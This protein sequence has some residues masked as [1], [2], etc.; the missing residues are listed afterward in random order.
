M[1]RNRCELL[2]TELDE[3]GAG[4]GSTGDLRVHV[5]ELLPG[6]RGLVQL[7]HR[8]PH[9][10]EAWGTLLRLVGAPSRDRVPTA[11]PAFGACGG[12]AWQHLSYPA[13]LEQKRQRVVHAFAAHAATAQLLVPAVRPSPAVLGYRNKGKYVVGTDGERVILGA[14]APRT[15]SIVATTGCQVVAP[16]IDEVAEWT[17][18]AADAAALVPYSEATH[19][20]E[21]RYVVIRANRLHDVLVALVVTQQCPV[22]KLERVAAALRNHPAIRTIVAVRNDRRDGAILPLGAPTEVLFGDGTLSETLADAVIQL[23]AVE[24]LQVNL[25]QADAMYSYVADCI[26]PAAG[27]RVVDL[28][29]GL[30]GISLHLAARGADVT[31]IE[32]ESA[33]IAALRQAATAAGRDID[34]RVG[35]A[36]TVQRVTPLPD[37]IVVNPPRKG[38]DAATRAALIALAPATLVYVS[39]GPQSLAADLVELLNAGYVVV[40][41]QPFDLMP[42][43]AQIETVVCLQRSETTNGATL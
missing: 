9:R 38:L 8:S 17:R 14:F 2:A 40:S 26:E 42:H 24:F 37:A 31:A 13:Q 34:A 30:G 19:Q 27:R 36:A 29:A 12:C 10:N 41:V 3:Y 7:Q 39:C 4:V 43:T 22:A 15:H 32:V 18:G 16:V 25:A 11:C 23:G 1:D 33:A 35:S 21:L 28:Y 6:E 5:P 20:G